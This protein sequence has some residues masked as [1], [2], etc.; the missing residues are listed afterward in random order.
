MIPTW[1][2][3]RT[4]T[5]QL[6]GRSTIELPEVLHHHLRPGAR[7]IES[8]TNPRVSFHAAQHSPQHPPAFFPCAARGFTVVYCH[9]LATKK[10]PPLNSLSIATRLGLLG[11]DVFSD[12]ECSA[13]EIKT[14]SRILSGSINTEQWFPY[15]YT[16]SRPPFLLNNPNVRLILFAGHGVLTPICRKRFG[17]TDMVLKVPSRRFAFMVTRFSLLRTTTAGTHHDGE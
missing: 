17:V 7:Y 11:S 6:Y 8:F 10:S 15:W 3:S 12:A 5:H 1:G 9:D 14:N 13:R 16:V 2:G 4:H